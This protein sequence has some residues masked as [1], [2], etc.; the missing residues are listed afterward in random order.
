MLEVCKHL[1]NQWNDQGI[2]YCHWKSNEHLMEGLDG[3]TDLDI[4]VYP[5]DKEKAEAQQE[6]ENA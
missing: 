4:Y 6:Q 2:R 3:E 1:F 5:T